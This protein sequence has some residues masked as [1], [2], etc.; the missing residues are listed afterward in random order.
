MT[1]VTLPEETDDLNELD[2]EDGEVSDDAPE[3][4]S[5]TPSVPEPPPPQVPNDLNPDTWNTGEAFRRGP[6]DAPQDVTPNLPVGQGETGTSSETVV[7]ADDTTAKTSWQCLTNQLPSPNC[8]IFKSDSH[9][10][11]EPQPPVCP[12]CGSKT[13]LV[14]ANS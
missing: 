1:E 12:T 9:L 2:T 3:E 13:V 14:V 6:G 7:M 11:P 8:P 4:S 5:E 10:L